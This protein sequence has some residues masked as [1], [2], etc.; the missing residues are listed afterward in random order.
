MAQ[1]REMPE[2][3]GNRGSFA[4]T[5]QSALKNKRWSS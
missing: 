1:P 4:G 5:V 3:G 2:R